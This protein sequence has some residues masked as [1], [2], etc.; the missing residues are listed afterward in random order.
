MM[1]DA[2]RI[3]EG[4]A[5][6]QNGMR[7]AD[8]LEERLFQIGASMEAI[9]LMQEQEDA[10]LHA[11]R[12]GEPLR[13]D[14]QTV[15]T[16]TLDKLI[17]ASSGNIL[18]LLQTLSLSL[19]ILSDLDAE[20]ILAG[21]A[22]TDDASRQEVIRTCLAIANMSVKFSSSE[23]VREAGA[24]LSVWLTLLSEDMQTRGRVLDRER[25]VLAAL[26]SNIWRPT[27]I[28]WLT[29]FNKRLLAISGNE[30]LA[31]RW[32]ELSIR[33]LL[34][35]PPEEITKHPPR[36]LAASLIAGAA[37]S[38][39]LEQELRGSFEFITGIDVE[40]FT[41]NFRHRPFESLR[42]RDRSTHLTT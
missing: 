42:A 23:T 19:S 5:T 12:R 8:E 40:T 22:S 9:G 13:E 30:P 11:P 10:Y 6:L 3:S 31:Q 33:S 17:P 16:Q 28:S 36:Q 34:M 41:S 4:M 7:H 26:K 2:T 38:L 24:R 14:L 29:I 39:G 1:G 15:A 21:P 35:V 32:G 18:Q 37:E 20:L 27:V 25:E